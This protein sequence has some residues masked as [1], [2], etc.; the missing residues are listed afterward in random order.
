MEGVS[1]RMPVAVAPPAAGVAQ[2]E[3]G[4]KAGLLPVALTGAGTCESCWGWCRQ[5]ERGDHGP[6]GEALAFHVTGSG[7]ALGQ[8]PRGGATRGA[9]QAGVEDVAVPGS[10]VVERV[11][12]GQPVG[13]AAVRADMAG[14]VTVDTPSVV[15]TWIVRA[16]A[17]SGLQ[18][19]EGFDCCPCASTQLPEVETLPMPIMARGAAGRDG[20]E[21]EA[22]PPCHVMQLLGVG[23]L[24]DPH[25]GITS[26]EIM[27]RAG[28]GI[29]AGEDVPD[30][31]R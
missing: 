18:G 16:V 26:R 21:G 10:T 24:P 5:V 12:A 14:S 23:P 20:V 31:S 30:I 29:D 7:G 8:V 13:G 19:V 9:A 6:C 4:L 15:V 22:C 11:I 3:L 2:G 17:V 25:E 1:V 28:V 27:A